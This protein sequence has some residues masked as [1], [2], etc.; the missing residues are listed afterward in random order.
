MNGENDGNRKI[1]GLRK[2]G[3]TVGY[4]SVALGMAFAALMVGKMDGS[5]MLQALLYTG[6]VVTAYNGIN[7]AKEVL[8]K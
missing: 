3:L 1:I 6:S 7:T 5:E 2:F 4:C 8:K